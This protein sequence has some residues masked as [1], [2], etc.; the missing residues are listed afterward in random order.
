MQQAPSLDEMSLTEVPLEQASDDPPE[1]SHAELDHDSFHAVNESEDGELKD[2]ITNNK[3]ALSPTDGQHIVGLTKPSPCGCDLSHSEKKERIFSKLISTFSRKNK[4]T[5]EYHPGKKSV[6][7]SGTGAESQLGVS[8]IR[9]SIQKSWHLIFHPEKISESKS[10]GSSQENSRKED[11]QTKKQ[12]ISHLVPDNSDIHANV[13][14][15]REIPFTETDFLSKYHFC[16]SRIIGKGASSVVRLAQGTRDHTVYA[17]KEFRKK[18]KEESQ[19]DY[20]KKLTSEYC[21]S[22]LFH[23]PNVVE[24]FDILRDGNHWYEVMEYCPG[25]DLF[26]VIRDGFLESEDVDICFKE[27]LIGVQYLH[28]MGVAHRDLKPENLLID[29][30]GHLKITDFGV[31]EVFHV[32]WEKSVHLSKGICGS[33][34]YIAPEVLSGKEY[35][36][37]KMDIWACGVIYYAMKFHGI[38]WAL[39]SLKDP[40]YCHYLTHRGIGAEPLVRLSRGPQNLLRK[41]LEPEPD[42]R[43]TIEE[44]LN[45]TWLK[46]IDT[47]SQSHFS[48]LLAS[49]KMKK[50]V[51]IA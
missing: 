33:A 42:K 32:A 36:A 28:Q 44:A 31:S 23:H 43:L 17:V 20:I 19:K 5:S 30:Q 22:S 9:K 40:N 6:S 48:E 12:E 1:L 15:E 2:V 47:H 21:I 41:M 3:R 10:S 8:D 7:A 24:T 26:S 45:D 4:S 25:G 14:A 37:A 13:M 50:N 51:S 11:Y 35:D 39:A 38:P 46:S 18:R 16:S 34:P 49:K 29:S 27:L